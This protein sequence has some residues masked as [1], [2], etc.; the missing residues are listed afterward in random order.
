MLVALL[1]AYALATEIRTPW[2]SERGPIRYTFEKLHKDTYNI[3]FWTAGHYKYANKAFLKHSF[4]SK[5]LTALI[6]NKADFTLNEIFPNAQVPMNTEFYSPYLKLWKMHPRATYTEWGLVTG[7]RWDYPVWKEK[8]GNVKGRIGLRATVPFRSIEIE[9][10]DSSD[11]NENPQSR[12]V[13]SKVVRTEVNKI[14]YSAAGGDAQDKVCTAYRFDFVRSLPDAYGNSI[15]EMPST[16]GV[17]IVGNQIGTETSGNLNSNGAAG[18]GYVDVT[19]ANPP[20][21]WLPTGNPTSGQ[22]GHVVVP[23]KS[24]VPCAIVR[25]SDGVIDCCCGCPKKCSCENDFNMPNFYAWMSTGDPVAPTTRNNAVYQKSTDAAMSLVQDANHVVLPAGDIV[26]SAYALGQNQ[27][28]VIQYNNVYSAANVSNCC[29]CN[30][31]ESLWLIFRRESDS[32]SQAK[33]ATNESGDAAGIGED[34]NDQIAYHMLK[35]NENPLVFLAR[36]GY[37]LESQERTGLGDIDLDLFYEHI[38]NKEWR[39]E[40]FLGVRF[41]TGTSKNQYG[42]PYKVMLGNGEH[43]EI[44]LGGLLAWQPVR[45][46]NIK[47]DLLWSFVLESKERRMAAFKC[48]CIKNMG[49]CTEADVD[50]G[51]LTGHFDFNFFHPKTDDI[52]WTLGYEIYYKTEDKVNYKCACSGMQSWLGR[53]ICATTTNCVT[54]YDYVANPQQLSNSLAEQNTESIAHK[55]RFEASFQISKYWELFAGGSYAFAGQNVMKDRDAHV[56]Y[57]YRF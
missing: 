49:P 5:P 51:Y 36:N 42:N 31:E 29:D 33:F 28:G 1:P 43:W 6:F 52:R 24:R 3:N 15:V 27:V 12:F 37:E 26:N 16:G 40:L 22:P 46:M 56:G 7:G 32:S 50:W 17:T 2:I 8:D 14:G 9:R 57:N 35:Y 21:A 34:I 55:V 53:K 18:S 30:K 41:P 13:K 25:G 54:T 11:K 45:W 38:F 20:A 48:A 44:K 10:Q 47:A 39:G 23:V 4:D 19:S